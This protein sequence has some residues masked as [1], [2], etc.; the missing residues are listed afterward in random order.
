MD[1]ESVARAV[2][3]KCAASDPWFPNP[4]TSTVYAW[5]EHFRSNQL[6][7][8]DCLEGVRLFYQD[9]G[10]DK[11]KIGDIVAKAR[12]VRRDRAQRTPNTEESVEAAAPSA[13]CKLCDEQGYVLDPHDLYGW[14]VKCTHM[15][16]QLIRAQPG[17]VSHQMT[18]V[19]DEEKELAMSRYWTARHRFP[20]YSPYRR[21]P[22]EK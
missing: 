12:E 17:H 21:S 6:S 3:A 1:Y 5:A 20:V 18:P 14:A 2:L 11:V 16:G 7:R 8:E 9:P 19:T 10:H 22:D 4:S 15:E 13:F